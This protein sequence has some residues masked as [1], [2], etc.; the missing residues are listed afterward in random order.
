MV[1]DTYGCGYPLSILARILVV[2][3]IYGEQSGAVLMP[4]I[5]LYIDGPT[6]KKIEAAA[7][8]EQVSISRW[9][10]GQLRARVEP[11]YPEGYEKLF[12]SIADATFTRPEQI[13]FE[14]DTVRENM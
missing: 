8:R 10:A 9:V 14:T 13:V 11:H 3:Y 5:S 1:A 6:L 4:Q 2:A 7:A 12:G